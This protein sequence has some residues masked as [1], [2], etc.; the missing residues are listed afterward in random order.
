MQEYLLV[1]ALEG[2]LTLVLNLDA[3]IPQAFSSSSLKTF[4]KWDGEHWR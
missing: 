1:M 2:V 4:S 3:A